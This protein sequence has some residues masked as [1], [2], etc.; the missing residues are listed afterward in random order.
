M[1]PHHDQIDPGGR[2]RE[3]MRQRVR[4]YI[5]A[6]PDERAARFPAASDCGLTLP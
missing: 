4:T 1:P 5:R 6:R 3:P 2:Q